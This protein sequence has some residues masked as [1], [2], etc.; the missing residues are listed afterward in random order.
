MAQL[1]GMSTR[2]F[3][4]YYFNVCTMDYARMSLAMDP[5]V[6]RMQA[7]D[8]VRLTGPGTSL[9]FSIKGQQAIKCAGELNIPDGEVFTA[10]VRDSAEG[11]L[12]YN[13]PSLFQ[14]QTHENIAFTF[15]KGKIVKATG[16]RE[17]L[18]NEI[19]DSD[20][21]A[22]FIGEFAIG[23]N[24]FITSPMKDTLFDEKIAGSFHFTPGRCYEEAPN[25]NDSVIHWDLVMIQTP[26]YGGG[27]MY[28]DDELIR[29][30][31]L[32]MPADL[33]GLNPEALKG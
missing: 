15:K 24:P 4:D 25:G 16:S 28:F 18:L 21:G 33:Q 30:D 22:R 31:G 13:T 32:F 23:V 3:E 26:E 29:R 5:L 14:G 12:R 10:P 6:E 2:A 11:T 27:D 9:S 7:C 19:L 1:A 20:E 17:A 8:R